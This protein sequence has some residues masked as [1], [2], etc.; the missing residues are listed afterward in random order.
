MAWIQGL[1][2]SWVGAEAL[3]V[4]ILA[5]EPSHPGPLQAKAPGRPGSTERSASASDGAG[6]AGGQRRF[7]GVPNPAL[8]TSPSP[9]RAERA[10]PRLPPAASAPNPPSPRHLGGWDVGVGTDSRI[11]RHSEGPRP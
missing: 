4:Q 8:Q 3:G 6:R 1:A 7:C 9:L 5:A 2:Q 10:H 11:R